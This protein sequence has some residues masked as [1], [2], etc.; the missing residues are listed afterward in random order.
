MASDDLERELDQFEVDRLVKQLAAKRKGQAEPPPAPAPGRV[1]SAFVPFG[2]PT[3]V[4]SP[5]NPTAPAQ[6]HHA[7]PSHSR[8]STNR[9]FMPTSSAGQARRSFAFASSLR[10]LGG[11]LH[12]PSVRAISLPAMPRIGFPVITDEQWAVITARMFVGLGIVLSIAMPYWPYSN[13]HSWGLALYL[14]AVALVV[15]TGIWG[16]KLTW[17]ARLGRAHTI[18]IATVIWGL[19]LATVAVLPHVGFVLG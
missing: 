2:S 5:S 12:F 16:S 19:N 11:S 6:T 8:W 18:A 7:A 9:I 3:A 13:S 1:P 4:P 14:F 10:G 15:I 17:D